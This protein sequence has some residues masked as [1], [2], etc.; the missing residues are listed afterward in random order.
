MVINTFRDGKRF[1]GINNDENMTIDAIIGNPPYQVM[2]GGGKGS[3]SISIFDKFV[4]LSIKTNPHYSSLIIPSRWFSGGKGLD[5]FRDKMLHDCRL[6][7]IND[8]FDATTCFPTADISGGICYF[9]WDKSHHGQSLIIS[10]RNGCKSS[11]KRPLLE[12]NCD[13]FIRFNE[14]V[15][16][17]RKI[18]ALKEK[19]FE[20]IVSTRKPFGDI[21]PYSS[22]KELKVYAYP[23]DGFISKTEVRQGEEYINRW[24]VF[25]TKAYGERGDFPYFVIGKPFIGMPNEICTET[26]LLINTIPE[27]EICEN[28]VS[29]MKTRFFRFCV[30]Q[31]K[32]TQNAARN[33]YSFVPIQDFSKKWTD[34]L[35]YNKYDL[36]KEEQNYIET[37]IKP[38]D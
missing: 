38:M 4:E 24:K 11:M 6:R 7:Q 13:A 5:E 31:K 3:S 12:E 19:S 32:S 23:N 21:K 28:V 27:K 15:S 16:I 36:T 9:L 8:F 26:Y 25:I 29:Y 18:L 14:S 37:V 34:E 30:L 20:S 35:L 17:M 1:W 33:V 2:D 10:E 22:Q